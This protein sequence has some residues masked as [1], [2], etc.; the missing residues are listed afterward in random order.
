MLQLWRITMRSL[1]YA[2]SDRHSHCKVFAI[3]SRSEVEAVKF[4]KASIHSP[5]WW[6]GYIITDIEPIGELWAA[7]G[8]TCP[9]EED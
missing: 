1:A 7:E 3:K 6:D 5:Q 2:K 4:A 8:F 9:M